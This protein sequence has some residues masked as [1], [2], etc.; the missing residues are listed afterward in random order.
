MRGI[1][2]VIPA[3][4]ESKS[5]R[6][7]LE[8]IREPLSRAGL[9]SEVIVVDDGSTDGTGDLAREA[10]VRV[11]AHGGGR[12]YG[13]ALKTGMEQASHDM[14]LIMDADGTYPPGAIPRL[15]EES[16]SHDMV[17]AAR[18]AEDVHIPLIRRPMKWLL[19]KLANYLA[20]IRIPD[21]NSGMRIFRKEVAQRFLY[22]LPAGFSFTSTLTLA[23]LCNGYR[24]AY[25]PI[26]YMKREGRSK[27]RPFP[28]TVNFIQLI[29]R[30]A[31]YFNPLKVFLPLGLFMAGFAVFILVFSYCFMDEV[32]DVTVVVI[33]MAAINTLTIGMLADLI[34]KRL[35]G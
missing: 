30:T 27:I 35:Q 33:F 14:I 10:G 3:H 32:A 24:V 26:N 28:D 15:V 34:D 16:R 19:T 23:M 13:A 21:L 12:G 22:L 20:G 11:V 29:V 17:V 5:I 6:R 7:V 2:V 31:L 18:V 25:V 4:N 8:E 9:P 1:S